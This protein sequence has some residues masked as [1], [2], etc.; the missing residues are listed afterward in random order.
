MCGRDC[1]DQFVL[2][3]PRS[4]SA[5]I[6]RD[7]QGYGGVQN[8][9]LVVSRAEEHVMLALGMRSYSLAAEGRWLSAVIPPASVL[10]GLDPERIEASSHDTE[11]R[12][13]HGV[14]CIE[15]VEARITSRLC[16]RSPS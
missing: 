16:A 8:R 5:T 15:H 13:C 9:E 6:L 11:I 3:V 7:I 14:L 4:A 2:R 1:R 10:A 12:V